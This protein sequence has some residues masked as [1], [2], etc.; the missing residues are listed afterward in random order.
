MK[1]KCKNNLKNHRELTPN[2]SSSLRLKPFRVYPACCCLCF[3]GVT[4]NKWHFMV[5]QS[6]MWYNCSYCF[7]VTQHSWIICCSGGVF[8]SFIFTS[9]CHSTEVR[10]RRG[11]RQACQGCPPRACH[12]RGC[13]EDP[14]V[15]PWLDPWVD[16][17][18]ALRPREVTGPMEVT[19]GAM[20]LLLLLPM[21][22]CGATSQ[23]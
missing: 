1:R 10:C 14:W 18:E 3:M 21:I 16:P 22:R 12:P 13:Q 17:W 7:G 6:S 2:L 5:H 15:A 4:C 19:R 11:P 9:P 20:V 8:N 23:P